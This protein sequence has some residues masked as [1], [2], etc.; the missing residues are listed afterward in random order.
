MASSPRQPP[1][2]GEA[3][4]A[5]F[6]ASL[7]TL[8]AALPLVAIHATYRQYVIPPADFL[9]PIA[10]AA[11]AAAIAAGARRWRASPIDL[12]LLSYAAVLAVSTIASAEPARSVV[13]LAGDA[14]L[15]ALAVLTLNYADTTKTTRRL[16]RAWLLGTAICVAAGLAGLVLFALGATEPASNPF[17]DTH[18]SLPPGAY[19]RVMASFI[20]S[21]VLAGYLAASA[22][23]AL[24]ARR[25]G[26]VP[27]A[28]ALW[29]VVGAAVVVTFSISTGIGGFLLVAGL[30]YARAHSAAR[31]RAAAIVRAAAWC[32]AAGFVAAA[33]VPPPGSHGPS[34]RMLTWASAWR[35]FHA[36]PWLGRGLGLEAADV[37]YTNAAGIIEVLTD[38]HNTWLS[39]M[40]QN[41]IL[42][43]AAL[44]WIVAVLI[45]TRRPVSEAALT[46]THAAALALLGGFLAQS[47]TGSFENQR[48][49]WVAAGLLAAAPR[50][51][52]DRALQ[53]IGASRVADEA[54]DHPADGQT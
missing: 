33:A 30:W 41:G 6:E 53:P 11:F 31:P 46:L 36:H 9:F 23:L 44:I 32:A 50:L 4:N 1:A 25:L 22:P 2:R 35:T 43:L 51:R 17:L 42:G 47:L 48:Y 29:L 28:A 12:P 34:S 45:R 14:Y 52:D 13:K 37:R 38:A 54:F 27:A 7:L 39:V 19:P 40:A 49:V 8:V 18:G 26:W 3:A 24:A 16:V 15:I 21:N 5:L 20:N 10:A